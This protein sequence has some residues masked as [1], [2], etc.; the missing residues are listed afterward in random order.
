MGGGVIFMTSWV[1]CIFFSAYR[2]T[3]FDDY[4][5]NGTDVGVHKVVIGGT[6]FSGKENI[7]IH[8]HL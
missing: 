1:A 4:F 7:S 6:V 8:L 3:F 2:T 5:V